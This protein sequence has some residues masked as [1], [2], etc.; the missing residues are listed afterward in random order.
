MSMSSGVLLGL[1]GWQMIPMIQIAMNIIMLIAKCLVAGGGVAG[2]M[3]AYQ[4]ARSGA[5]IIMADE[6]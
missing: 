6:A 4:A 1:A 2:L 5:R 3:A